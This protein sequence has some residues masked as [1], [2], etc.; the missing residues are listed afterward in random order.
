MRDDRWTTLHTIATTHYSKIVASGDI[1]M[2][3]KLM[4]DTDRAFRMVQQKMPKLRGKQWEYR[5]YVSGEMSKEE[6]LAMSDEV[7]QYIV[8]L[9]LF[10]G[11][12]NQQN[13]Q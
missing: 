9:S 8:Q 12:Q 5:Q 13:H 7:E 2:L 3:Y 6:Y 10:T 1:L 4:S 11:E